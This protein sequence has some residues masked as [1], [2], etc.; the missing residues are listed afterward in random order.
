MI[1]DDDFNPR[2]KFKRPKL[3]IIYPWMKNKNDTNS[4]FPLIGV[5]V[6]ADWMDIQCP[7][8]K[9]KYQLT[10]EHLDYFNS[11]LWLQIVKT[12]FIILGLLKFF[13]LINLKENVFE[14]YQLFN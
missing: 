2:T 10:E 13:E 8:C 5:E 7:N 9:N 4:G 14:F 11:P 12:I 3:P 6:A 1:L